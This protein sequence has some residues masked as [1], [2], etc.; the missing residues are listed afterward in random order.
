[1]KFLVSSKRETHIKPFLQWCLSTYKSIFPNSWKQEQG[2]CP[3]TSLWMTTGVDGV[4][5][6]RRQWLAQAQPGQFLSADSGLGCDFTASS[7]SPD[8][9][10]P[11]TS[12]PHQ[13]FWTTSRNVVA[14]RP[15]LVVHGWNWPNAIFRGWADTGRWRAQFHKPYFFEKPS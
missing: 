5:R 2:S 8:K 7:V 13:P 15:V 9:T 11:R 6:R 1:M 4:R 14:A 12:P 10:A 3:G